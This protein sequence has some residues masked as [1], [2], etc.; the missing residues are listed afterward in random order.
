M[1]TRVVARPE[2]ECTPCIER[3]VALRPPQPE[4]C[5]PHSGTTHYEDHVTDKAL[6]ART[7]MLALLF[8]RI[9]SRTLQY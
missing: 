9:S 8:Y 5:G 7:R 4:V 6:K 2:P 1:S 3:K